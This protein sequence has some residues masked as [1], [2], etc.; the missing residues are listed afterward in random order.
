[1][2]NSPRCR[3]GSPPEVAGAEAAAKESGDDLALLEPVVAAELRNGDTV[4]SLASAYN[5]QVRLIMLTGGAK[6][7]AGAWRESHR[8]AR[9]GPCRYRQPGQDNGRAALSESH[10]RIGCI[11]APG[12][13][14]RRAAGR[15]LRS[16]AA[17]SPS[18]P[19]RQSPGG[20]F[21][22]LL[23]RFADLLRVYCQARLFAE[24]D[25]EFTGHECSR[26]G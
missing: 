8:A 7:G 26:G 24:P 16:P 12:S 25:Q 6:G 14:D 15:Q 20:R 3:S 13:S 23:S 21:A 17:R 5:Q 10:Q 2:R 19:S 22:S 18:S 1:M 11:I 4:M 9:I